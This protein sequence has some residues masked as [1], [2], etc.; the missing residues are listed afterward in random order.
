MLQPLQVPEWKWEEIAMNFV[1]G[2]P[3]TQFGYDSLW[4]IVN[5]LAK[6][7]HLIPVKMTYIIPQLA[8]LYM[9]N[10]VYLHGGLSPI[11]E[12]HLF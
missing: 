11:E 2:L 1:V 4:V 6:L 7:A 10:I 3:R 9:S 5:R 8:M 12:P